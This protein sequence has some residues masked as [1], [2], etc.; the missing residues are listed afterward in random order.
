MTRGTCPSLANSSLAEYGVWALTGVVL[1]Y[2]RG[3]SFTHSIAGLCTFFLRSCLGPIPAKLSEGQNETVSKVVEGL[4]S[5][6]AKRFTTH[7]THYGI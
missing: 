6:T 2:V 1:C 3:H 4:S 5:I 7:I